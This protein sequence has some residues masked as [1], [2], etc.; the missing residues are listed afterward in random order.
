MKRIKARFG[1]PEAQRCL[2]A[3]ALLLFNWP[4]LS[5]AGEKGPF[6]LYIYLFIVW[7]LIILLI[8]IIAASVEAGSPPGTGKTG[9]GDV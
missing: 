9:D 1:K 7:L 4:L 8:F 2:F 5:I 6:S 3:L